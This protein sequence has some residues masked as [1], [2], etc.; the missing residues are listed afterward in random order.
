MRMCVCMCVCSR[1]CVPVCV[2]VCLYHVVSCGDKLHL[3]AAFEVEEIVTLGGES[4]HII[5]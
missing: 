5:E 4:S 2:R 1:A 3:G